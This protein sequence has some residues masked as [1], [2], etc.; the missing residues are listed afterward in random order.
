LV[1]VIDRKV[2]TYIPEKGYEGDV[3]IRGNSVANEGAGTVWSF[4]PEYALGVSL[5]RSQRLPSAEE[6]Y[7]DGPHAATRTVEL[8]DPNLDEETSRNLELSL[9][10]VAGRTQFSLSL[11]RNEVDDFIYAADT[12]HDVGGGYREI[13]YRQQDAVLTGA[14]GE[15]R[16]QLVDATALTLFGDHVR[17]KL[18]SG[19][20]LPRIPADRLGLRLD[21]S[22]TQA[23]GGQVE[24]YRVQRQD[25]LADYE[26]ETG[27][28]NM[29][30]AS[31]IYSGRLQHAD[32]QL[33]MKGSN[34]LDAE[35][36]NHSSFIKDE[37]VLPGRNLTFGVR[38]NF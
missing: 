25:E 16:Y 35:G 30:G 22:F 11:Y 34:L 8:G 31:L 33:Y 2:P 36:R 28:Y 13:Q 6:L 26:S 18:R 5:S 23:L 3:E 21:Q 4:A 17:G 24:F 9:R 12:G 32:Y 10:K 19:G 20:D 14:E 15:V 38:L 37:V 27:G 29:L 1:N 7:A